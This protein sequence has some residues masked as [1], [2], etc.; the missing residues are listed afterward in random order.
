MLQ[1]ISEKELG[2]R[3]WHEQQGLRVV[4]DIETL[5][6]PAGKTQNLMLT[7]AVRDGIIS[8]CGEV[9]STVLRPRGEALELE[10]IPGPGRYDP[11]TWEGCV[12]K[13]ADKI[14]Y[15]GRDIE[16]AVRLRILKKTASPCVNF[17][18]S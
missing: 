6:D 9:R 14:A 5:L 3:F 12:V 8:H 11:Y 16:D 10:E 15:L 18:A 17:C 4:D 2:R 7:Y 13:V 1:E